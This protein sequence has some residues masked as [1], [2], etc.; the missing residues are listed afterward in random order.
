VSFASTITRGRREHRQ[1]AFSSSVK[2]VAITRM[3]YFRRAGRDREGAVAADSA[4]LTTL[5]GPVAV[6]V[7][8][9]TAAPEDR[10]PCRA[11]A[12]RLTGSAAERRAPKKARRPLV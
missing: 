6:M 2:P 1:L 4:T 9:G 5:L 8:L 11:D 3:V 7:A 12:G 10:E